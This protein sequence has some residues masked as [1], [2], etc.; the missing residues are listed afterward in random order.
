[1]CFQE[2]VYLSNLA[3]PFFVAVKGE[4]C[5]LSRYAL[6]SHC[7]RSLHGILTMGLVTS[8]PGKDDRGSPLAFTYVSLKIS[9]A[10]LRQ[11]SGEVA[12][13]RPALSLPR[14]HTPLGDPIGFVWDYTS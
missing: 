12:C 9:M 7:S 4:G 2:P 5:L 6:L 8:V 3:P 1:M 13:Q 10:L 14:A 11:P